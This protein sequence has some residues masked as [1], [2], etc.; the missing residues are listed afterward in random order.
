MEDPGFYQAQRAFSFAGANVVPRPVDNERHLIA[1]PSKNHSPKII[2]VTPSHQFLLGMTM[3]LPPRT[4]LI[5]FARA[6]DAYIFEDDHN[7]ESRALPVLPI[8]LYRP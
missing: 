6:H 3:G 7:S 4:A 5:S 8:H 2:Y 1:P